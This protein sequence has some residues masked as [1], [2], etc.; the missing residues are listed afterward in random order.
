[1]QL[2]TLRTTD[3]L[4]VAGEAW[5][6]LWRRSDVTVPVAQ[7]DLIA[8]W[9]DHWARGATFRAIVVEH[10]GRFI[11]A[12]PL[13]GGQ[14]RRVLP[15]G[16][17]PANHCAWA[18]DLMLD[19]AVDAGESL[20]VLVEGLRRLPWSVVWIQAAPLETRRWR[21]LLATA[22]QHRLP[23]A[24]REIFR[25]GQIE[26]DHDWETYQASWSSNH[27]RHVRRSQAR[28][29]DEGGVRA[30][31]HRLIAD[32]RVETFVRQAFAIESLGW[33]GRRGTSTSQD[34]RA[35]GYYIEQARLLASRGQLQISLLEQHGRPIA[36]EYG[37]QAKGVYFS[38]KVGYDEAFAALSPGQLLRSRLLEQFFSDPAQRLF[39]FAGPLCEATE[40][41]ITGSYMIGRAAIGV[42][43]PLGPLFVNACR[44][45]WGRSVFEEHEGWKRR[46]DEGLMAMK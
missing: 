14:A 8:H 9:V 29:R 7:A 19:P 23:C 33:K 31:A 11:A 45:W 42:R 34:R 25:I 46:S 12:L 16:T 43:K 40:K 26:I 5:D 37:W 3:E 32:D 6:D 20:A 2:L 41:W 30:V 21:R 22:E 27:R 35:L 44:R 18:G 1:M 10:E 15:V 4:R 13:V 17:M 39:D 28:A 36:F 38:P 24:W